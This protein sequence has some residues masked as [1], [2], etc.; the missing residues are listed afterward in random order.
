MQS[1]RLHNQGCE[2]FADGIWKLANVQADGVSEDEAIKK[3]Q[4]KQEKLQKR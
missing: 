1:K 3:K 4:C 2:G